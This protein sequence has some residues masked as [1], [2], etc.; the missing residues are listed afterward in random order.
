M[1]NI[2]LIANVTLS[3]Y[4]DS[5]NMRVCKASDK[6]HKPGCLRRSLE[7]QYN[8]EPSRI[9][10]LNVHLV[11]NAIFLLSGIEKADGKPR[12]KDP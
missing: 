9:I 2:N 11:A 6:I 4:F 7:R 3:F 8:E 1:K 10:Q 5:E 12:E